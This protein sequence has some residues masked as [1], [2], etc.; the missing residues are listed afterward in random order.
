MG[1]MLRR[2]YTSDDTKIKSEGV[3]E[4]VTPSVDDKVEEVKKPR[5]TVTKEK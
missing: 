3:A 4:K 5:K 2:H 1:M